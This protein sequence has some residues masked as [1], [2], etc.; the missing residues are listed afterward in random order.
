MLSFQMSMLKYNQSFPREVINVF[1]SHILCLLLQS[2]NG[3]EEEDYVDD[4]P[5]IP[6]V[7][8]SEFSE[9]GSRVDLTTGDVDIVSGGSH[10][11]ELE[12]S[13]RT[14]SRVNP[15]AQYVDKEMD[16]LGVC[17]VHVS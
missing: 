15:L 9:P 17:L 11:N 3:Q 4:T 16:D 10:L 5:I 7:E 14:E 13:E 8:E 12:D 1:C 2:W 6:P